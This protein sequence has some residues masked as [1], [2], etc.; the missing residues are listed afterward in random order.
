[1]KFQSFLRRNTDAP[2]QI[3][4]RV[5]ESALCASVFF[6][7]E[8]WLVRNLKPTETTYNG[9]LKNLLGVR[10]TSCNDLVL[11]ESGEGGAPAYIARRQ[12]NFLQG[13]TNRPAYKDSY[14]EWVI[15]KAI[16]CRCPAGIVLQSLLPMQTDPVAR[17]LS[18]IQDRI[19]AS[20]SSRRLRY[21]TINPTLSVSPVY[22]NCTPEHLRLAF[23]R[24]RLGSHRLRFEMGRW[25]RIPPEQ[26]L[27]PCGDVQNEA[28]LLLTCPLTKS[29]RDSVNIDADNLIELF[30]QQDAAQLCYKI[31]LI[32]NL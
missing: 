24:L 32:P 22:R 17:H 13:L 14:L 16:D 1:M 3:K 15:E 29:A 5:W 4:K 2:F 27:C 7:C 12:I 25:S 9:T 19:K 30:S 23:T 28:H 11:V 31:L 6:S 21:L 18:A 26:R 8:T 20:Q 10:A